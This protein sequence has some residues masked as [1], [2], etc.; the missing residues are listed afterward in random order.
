MLTLC[1]VA[2]RLCKGQPASQQWEI[3][4]A[5]EDKVVI[6]DINWQGPKF[7]TVDELH[8]AFLSVCLVFRRSLVPFALNKPYI[9]LVKCE[10]DFD[11]K[12]PD[13]IL[14]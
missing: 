11:R 10:K 6:T 8:F 13:M 9:F 1:R 14:I 12:E 3:S 7:S 2:Q 5:T 4:H